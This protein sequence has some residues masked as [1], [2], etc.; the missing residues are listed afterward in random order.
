MPIIYPFYKKASKYH[1]IPPHPSLHI[2]FSPHQPLTQLP[3]P[4]RI[5]Q[6]TRERRTLLDPTIIQIPPIYQPLP[7]ARQNNSST[8][9]LHRLQSRHRPSHR[10]KHPRDQLP[11]RI[12]Q[13]LRQPRPVDIPR[14][15]TPR[16]HPL[17]RQRPRKQHV[18]ALPLPVRRPLVIRPPVLEVPVRKPHV[19]QGVAGRGHVHDASA[20]RERREQEVREEEWPEVVRRELHLDAVP[21]CRVFVQRH[22]PRVVQQRVDLGPQRLDGLGGAPHRGEVGQLDLDEMHGGVG[23]D[24][25]ERVD[26]GLG[27]L[28][29]AA[30][31]DECPWGGGG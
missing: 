4:L 8:P 30:E 9:L 19:A 3:Q 5:P 20:G 2:K 28:R 24:G 11:I 18:G 27:F 16:L 26:H 14:M 29:G 1:E 15:Q 21:V 17:P 7:H 13:I 6:I 31:E 12:H 25:F 23:R 22:N 10:F